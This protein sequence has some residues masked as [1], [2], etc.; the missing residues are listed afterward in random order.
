MRALQLSTPCLVPILRCGRTTKLP[1]DS[2]MRHF[3]LQVQALWHWVTDRI[4][5]A[6]KTT[7]R[8]AARVS[9]RFWSTNVDASMPM[10]TCW[11][12]R[13]GVMIALNAVGLYV[14]IYDRALSCHRRLSRSFPCS[15]R[16]AG[17]LEIIVQIFFSVSM[18]S[19]K[20][21]AIS[22]FATSVRK[23]RTFED[24]ISSVLPRPRSV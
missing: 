3:S 9:P 17:M 19:C 15:D 24:L 1:V 18:M 5:F 13:S 4:H 23:G 11:L 10:G 14:K 12:K 20:L 6:R 7:S 21:E 2:I 8:S 16:M 22:L